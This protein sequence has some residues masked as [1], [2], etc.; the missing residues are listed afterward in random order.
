ME[1]VIE[2]IFEIIIEGSME[3]WSEKKLPMPL[4]ILAAIIFL[5]FYLGFVGVFLFMG[6]N[7][8]IDHDIVAA[9][10]FFAVGFGILIAVIYL[11]RKKFNEKRR[12]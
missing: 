2:L 9:V 10:L 4:R 1:F 12:L 11:I 6:Y 7:A 3:I 5:V 8:M